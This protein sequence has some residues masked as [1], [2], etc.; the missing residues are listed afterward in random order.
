M[1]RVDLFR[2]LYEPAPKE[3]VAV[4]RLPGQAVLF[5]CEAAFRGMETWAQGNA[6][7]FQLSEDGPFRD[8]ELAAHLG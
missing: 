3:K 6:T 5:P 8:P 7:G 4:G 1:D 2:V